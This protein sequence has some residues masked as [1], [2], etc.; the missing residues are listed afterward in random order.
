MD[1]ARLGRCARA[2]TV[3]VVAMVLA[4]CAPAAAT[5]EGDGIKRLYDLFLIVG[6]LI[7][8]LVAGLI[9]WSILRYRAPEDGGL[10]PQTAA[11]LKLELIWWALPTILVVIL[12]F[13]TAG[14]LNRVDARVAEGESLVIRVTGFQWQWRFEYQEAGVTIT[15]TPEAL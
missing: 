2:L 12:F 6:A 7:F 1:S 5:V 14:V 3:A 11:N 10:P 9:G 4:G 13:M 15:G 8:V